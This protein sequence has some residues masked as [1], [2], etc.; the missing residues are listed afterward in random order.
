MFVNIY[1]E[2]TDFFPDIKPT[3]HCWNQNWIAS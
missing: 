1:P 2:I 3:K